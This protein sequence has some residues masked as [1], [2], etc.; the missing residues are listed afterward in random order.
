MISLMV[1]R[2]SKLH[3]VAGD[4]DA[5]IGHMKPPEFVFVMCPTCHS[6]KAMRSH[7]TATEF[8]HFCT[9]C[10]HVWGKPKKTPK[11]K[12]GVATRRASPV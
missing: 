9:Q 3:I 6:P 4:Q 12:R 5:I 7:E 1:A 2:C 11:P 10:Q 8:V